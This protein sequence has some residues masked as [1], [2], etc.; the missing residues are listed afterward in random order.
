M[1]VKHGLIHRD[2]KDENLIVNMMNGEVKLVDFGATAS[3]EKAMKKEFQGELERL[4]DEVFEFS[5]YLEMKST[6]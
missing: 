4:G 6:A 1:Y 3:A 5:Y 2:I